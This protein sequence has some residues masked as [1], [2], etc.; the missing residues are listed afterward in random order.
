[1]ADPIG[2][3]PGVSSGV[4]WKGLVDQIITLDRRPAVKMEKSIAANTKRKESLELFRA[5]MVALKTASD[6]LKFGSAFDSYTANA[7]G[8]AANGRNV[9]SAAA[10]STAAPGT[11]S[12]DVLKLAQA[13]K[14]VGTVGF[15]SSSTALALTGR[16]VV[17]G[18]NVDLVAADTL[19]TVRDKINL[20]SAT[21]NVQATI[22]AANADGTG[23]QLV[24]TSTKTGLAGAFTVVDDPGNVAPI[25]VALGVDG[26]PQVPAQDALLRIDNAVTVSRS[27]NSISDAIPGVTLTLGAEGS[28]ALTVTRN[29]AAAADAVK[30]FVDAYNKVQSLVK[31]Q[32]TD[33]AA[34]LNRDGMIR[35]TRATLAQT[36]L[37]AGSGT[38]VATDLANL[39]AV[40][41]SMQKDGTLKFESATW[42][43]A[44]PSRMD[45]VKALLADRMGAVSTYAGDVTLPFAGQVDQRSAGLTTQSAS[46]QRRIDDIDSRL[47]KKRTALLLQYSRSET[48]LGKLKSLGD[49]LA[50]QLMGLN[51]SNDN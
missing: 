41:V 38:G 5:A 31:A 17:G 1:M 36:V 37:K 33:P 4:D 32:T 35:A 7:A 51:A 19:A 46:L 30:A 34:P 48:M 28:S 14:T 25:A 47:D 15:A 43:A 6:A 40:G 24:L 44:Y 39:S 9:V 49:S 11:Y 45:D 21:S 23:Q 10:S 22:V 8:V 18:Q 3:V 2:S 12:L 20:T 29:D 50:S 13:Q 16:L 27:T 42:N 26:A